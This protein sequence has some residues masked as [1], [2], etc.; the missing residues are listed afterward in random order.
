MDGQ[1]ADLTGAQGAQETGEFSGDFADR[2][3]GL[4]FWY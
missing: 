1:N 3:A 2:H 4:L